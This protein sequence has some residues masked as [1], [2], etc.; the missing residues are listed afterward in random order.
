MES[1]VFLGDPWKS[2]VATI[3]QKGGSFWV[4]INPYVIQKNGETRC[5]LPPTGLQNVWP[6]VDF[7]G[8]GKEGKFHQKSPLQELGRGSQGVAKL[9]KDAAGREFCVWGN[10]DPGMEWRQESVAHFK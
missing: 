4:L 6:T 3:L 2:L 5:Q 10:P 9:A 1:D 7:Q 8:D